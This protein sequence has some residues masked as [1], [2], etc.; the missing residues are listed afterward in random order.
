M[1]NGPLTATIF[2]VVPPRIGTTV[3]GAYLLFIHIA[4]DSVAFPLIG[5]LS[6]HFGLHRA[7]YLLPSAALV[8][9]LIVLSA[10]RFL[11]RDVERAQEAL[12]AT[13]T[14]SPA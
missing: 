5:A 9:G 11:T 3:V 1:Y 8:G 6:D 14:P 13:E 2:D 4:G 10:S 7:I 12:K